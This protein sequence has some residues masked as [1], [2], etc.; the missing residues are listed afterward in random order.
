MLEAFSHMQ[1]K[2]LRL[3]GSGKE[4][5]EYKAKASG[6]VTF[7]G[8]LNR[9]QLI[10]QIRGCIAVIAASQWYETFGMIIIEAYAEH[11]PVAVGNIGSIGGLVNDGVTGVKFQYDSVD[12][13]VDKI[14]K[15]NEDMGENG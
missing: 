4:L 15:I 3:A 10:D 5:E 2:E 1:G 13:L 12:D 7:L 8:Q 11:R 9:L 14:G 6:N